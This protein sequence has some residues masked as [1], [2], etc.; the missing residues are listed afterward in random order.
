MAQFRSITD[1]PIYH[2]LYGLYKMLHSYQNGIPKSQRY[3]LW[4]KCENITLSLL[5][6]LIH[7]G[8]CKSEERTKFLHKMSTQLD[9]LKVLFRLAKD[10]LCIDTKQYL[11][12]QDFVQEIGKM[13][14]GWI[15][16][17][18]QRA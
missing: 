13:I 16:S 12:I 4:L 11:V 15:K 2:K 5:E 18:P 3:S 6:T 10:T 14:G 1:V 9:L 7:I 8:G 17:V